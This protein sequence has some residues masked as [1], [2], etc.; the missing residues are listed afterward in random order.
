MKPAFE[1]APGP[2]EVAVVRR[3]ATTL[4]VNRYGQ[5]HWGYWALK[6]GATAGTV[7][8]VPFAARFRVYWEWHR[9]EGPEYWPEWSAKWLPRMTRPDSETRML[10]AL[11]LRWR[12]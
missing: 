4:H 8:V 11:R 6:A 12:L 10:N 1:Q 9:R 3:W 5:K 7:V 2:V